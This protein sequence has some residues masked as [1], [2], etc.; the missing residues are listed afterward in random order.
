MRCSSPVK[1]VG[2][3]GA[4]FLIFVC[5]AEAGATSSQALPLSPAPFPYI[6]SPRVCVCVLCKSMPYSPFVH[7]NVATLLRPE[8]ASL[9]SVAS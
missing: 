4:D 6:R 3:G 5:S 8:P 7:L 1:V 9:A 2:V